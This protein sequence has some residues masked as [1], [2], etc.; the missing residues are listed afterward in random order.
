ME[1]GEIKELL[2]NE[3]TKEQKY[4]L[5]TKQA[6]EAWELL[7][8]LTNNS[9]SLIFLDPQYEPENV[10]SPNKRKHPH[11]KP[12][13]LIEALILATTNE[14]DLVVDPC[15]GSFIVLEICQELGRNYL[16]VDLTY[17]EMKEFLSNKPDKVNEI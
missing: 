1:F 7:T 14:G 9:V 10:L 13:E 5:N 11:Q 8:N 15:A 16:G 2:L 17:K 12:K 6:G 4:L 3:L